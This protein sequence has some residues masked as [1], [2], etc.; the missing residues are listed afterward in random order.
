V[1]RRAAADGLI[2]TTAGRRFWL[3]PNFATGFA[4]SGQRD[5]WLADFGARA[6]FLSAAD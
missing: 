5:A 1:W 6:I 4:C 2:G 3:R